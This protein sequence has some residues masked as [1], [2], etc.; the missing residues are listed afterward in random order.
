M[1]PDFE[2][3]QYPHPRLH[4]GLFCQQTNP[5]TKAKHKVTIENPTIVYRIF[6]A[7]ESRRLEEWDRRTRSI[8]RDLTT[9][10]LFLRTCKNEID[11]LAG[12]KVPVTY[13]GYLLKGRFNSHLLYKK[14]IS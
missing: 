7:T 1:G 8:F 6:S 9:K 5:I 11:M 4:E 3:V 14:L 13:M 12:A 10:K 2:Y